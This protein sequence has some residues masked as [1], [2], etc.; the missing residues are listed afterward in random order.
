MAPNNEVAILNSVNTANENILK[1]V[2]TVGELTGRLDAKEK[3]CQ[4]CNADNQNDHNYI[5]R[6]LKESQNWRAAH[7]AAEKAEEKV[8]VQQDQKSLSTWQ[9]IAAVATI[10]GV[11]IGSLTGLVGLAKWALTAL[12]VKL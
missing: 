4:I 1:L 6:E 10:F 5:F 3:S 2:E 7:D 9:K 12:G 11:L 8:A